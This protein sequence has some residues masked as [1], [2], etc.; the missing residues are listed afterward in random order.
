MPSLWAMRS[1]WDERCA[2]AG[3]RS[4]APCPSACSC[5][6]LTQSCGE[7]IVA[8]A[9]DLRP[10]GLRAQN[11]AMSCALLSPPLHDRR[12]G[13]IP[14]RILLE[15]ERS[16]V[17]FPNPSNIGGVCRLAAH[18]A[19]FLASPLSPVRLAPIDLPVAVSRQWAIQ[20]SVS[21]FAPL[22]AVAT[23]K[24]RAAGR[25][26]RNADEADGADD[27]RR[28]TPSRRRFVEVAAHEHNVVMLTAFVKWRNGI[29]TLLSQSSE[30]RPR[31]ADVR[32]ESR[33]H[34]APG[35]VARARR[36]ARRRVAQSSAS[37]RR[38]REEVSVNRLT[39]WRGCWTFQRGRNRPCRR[40][41]DEHVATI[42]LE[43]TRIG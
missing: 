21:A 5:R 2:L 18:H 30:A 39:G 3:S 12:Y 22:A 29:V 19:L 20:L 40:V 41:R 11:D 37:A 33:C 25:C 4:L 8:V 28:L 24:G 32:A 1:A 23:P 10:R 34:R 9:Y 36:V 16:R 7:A 35:A 13:C 42:R 43:R 38:S 31:P 27:V 26:M 15:T 6:T 17:R 14:S